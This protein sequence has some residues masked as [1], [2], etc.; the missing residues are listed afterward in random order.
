MASEFLLLNTKNALVLIDELYIR[1]H[2]D[3]CGFP[4]HF[5]VSQQPESLLAKEA[6]FTVQAREAIMKYALII[7]LFYA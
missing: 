5:I 2:L 7:S 3:T 1:N 6:T 4:L